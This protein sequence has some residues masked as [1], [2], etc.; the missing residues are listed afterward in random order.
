MLMVM[1]LMVN[2]KMIKQM[3]LEFMCI[4]MDLDMKDIGEMIFNMVW[5][6]R[7][8][9]MDQSMLECIKMVKRVEMVGIN[10][11]MDLI[12]KVNGL[13]IK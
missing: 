4:K 9:V 6:M 3:D 7:Y 5:V 12:M 10:G 1:Y 8:G 13:I 2:G 11:L